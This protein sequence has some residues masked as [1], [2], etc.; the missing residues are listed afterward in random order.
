M[1]TE[2]ELRQVMPRLSPAKLAAYL[3][4]L[5]QA[6]REFKIA[7]RLREAAFL[8]QLA[9]ESGEFRWVEEIWGPTPAQ[10]RYEDRADL[11]NTQAGDGKRFRGRGFIQLTGRANYRKYGRLLGLDLEGHPELAATPEVG[12]RVAA[13]YWHTHGLN[14]L[15]DRQEFVTITR[16]IN[17]GTNGLPDRQR[18]YRKA[19]AILSDRDEPGGITVVVNDRE[20]EE[21]GHFR[22]NAAWVPL[23]SAVEALGW[24]IASL[25]PADTQP[26][27]TLLR[28][29]VRRQVP[30][31]ISAAGVGYTPAADLAEATGAAKQWDPE[32]RTVTLA[33]TR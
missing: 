24:H 31:S 1:V 12:F 29:E 28:R 27:A 23:R 5:Q 6:M 8:A 13:L 20:L 9:H 10:R 16:R 17:G 11:G 33:A 30:L 2:A 15:A 14:A 26:T 18:Y 32:D 25:A 21:A 3:P 4:H 22:G 7:G 19:L